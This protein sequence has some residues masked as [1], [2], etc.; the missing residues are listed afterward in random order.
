MKLFLLTPKTK[1]KKDF[2]YSREKRK[3]ICLT[4]TLL[5]K[6]DIYDVEK[7]WYKPFI[8]VYITVYHR[9]LVMMC[10][11]NDEPFLFFRTH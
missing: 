1:T 7:T 3:N 8:T 5:S 6:D 2:S 10:S 4:V 9:G 11:L